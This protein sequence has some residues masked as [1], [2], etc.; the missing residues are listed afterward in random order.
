[1]N[2]TANRRR[3]IKKE[4]FLDIEIPTPSIKMQNTIIHLLNE[5]EKLKK[6]AK[7]KIEESKNMTNSTWD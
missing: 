1:M 7:L 3:S 4:V 6:R 2:R 5:A